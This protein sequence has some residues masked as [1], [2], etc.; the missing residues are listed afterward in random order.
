M[1]VSRRTRWRSEADLSSAARYASPV[2]VH[3]EREGDPG[4]VAKRPRIGNVPEADRGEAHS[5][6]PEQGLVVAQLRDV[7]AAEDSAVVTEE[8][9]RRGRVRPE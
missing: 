2:H 9:E 8:H 4:L 5:A 6:R 3:Q 7:L 1:K